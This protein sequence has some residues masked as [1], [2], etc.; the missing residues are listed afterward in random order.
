MD[1]M[2]VVYSLHPL[3]AVQNA[4]AV[5]PSGLRNSPESRVMQ[6]FGF[7]EQDSLDSLR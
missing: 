1:L 3:A 7:G 4:A 6:P 5:S 2:L